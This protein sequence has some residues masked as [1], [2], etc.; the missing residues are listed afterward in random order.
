[1]QK[2]SG[3]FMITHY[4]YDKATFCNNLATFYQNSDLNM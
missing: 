1:M 2:V 3:F 4:S